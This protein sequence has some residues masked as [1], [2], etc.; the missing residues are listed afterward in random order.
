MPFSRRSFLAGCCSAV[1]VTGMLSALAQLRVIGAL[2]QPDPLNP[3]S[4]AAASDY[5]ALICLFLLG[6]N[7][8]NN[9]IIPYDKASFATYQT[10][11]GALALPYDKLLP[12]T[13]KRTDGRSWALHPSFGMDQAGNV[14]QGLKNLFDQGKLAFLTN[15]GTLLYPTT[16]Q[17]YSAKSVPLPP[18]LFSHNDQQVEWQSSLAD[19]P[20]QT[21]WGGRLADLSNAFNT[22]PAVSMSVSL[23]GQNSF[24]VGKTINSLSVG[25]SGPVALSGSSTDKKTLAGQRTSAFNDIISQTNSNLFETAFAGLTRDAI[26]D[27]ALLANVLSTPAPFTNAFPTTSLG[28][29]LKM[30]ARLI[31]VAPQLGLKRQIFFARVGGFDLHDNQV[32]AT[33]TSIGAHANLIADLS[34][35]MR[36]LYDATAQMGLADSVTTFTASDF[37]RTYNTN[38]R[39]SDHGWGSHHMIMGGAVNGGDLYG[40][41]PSMVINGPDDTGRGRWIPSTSVDEYSARLAA[42]FG[43]SATDI[44]TILPNIGRFNYLRTEL[45]FI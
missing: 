2:A 19:K 34:R 11:R 18:Q 45:G 28:Q 39:G 5:K 22:N 42:W 36:A 17:Q 31:A 33:D 9:M 37:G 20:F 8:A 32:D 7:D 14:D 35:S 12:I 10:S 3:G 1:T 23:N 26:A 27:S 41:M 24:Q 15:T 13:T 21:G 25:T 43:V 4:T 40:L 16:K 29:Q 44:P 6:G 30:I 38:G